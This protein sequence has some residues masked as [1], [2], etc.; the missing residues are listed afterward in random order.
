M[1]LHQVI[2]TVLKTLSKSMKKGVTLIE[3]LAVVAVVLVIFSILVFN[4]DIAGNKKKTRDTKRLADLA[5][6]DRAINEFQ[7]DSKSYPDS[8]SV[9][10]SSHILPP[11]NTALENSASGWI[12]QDFSA[13][14]SKMP[15]DPINDGD[16]HYAYFS[17]GSTYEIN[18]RL[19]YYLEKS[20][21][22][23]GNDSEVFEDGNNLLLISP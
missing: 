18:A 19:E 16:Y 11:G 9:L 17:N 1:A 14:M 6:L 4:I 8:G 12:A 2:A 13:Y 7:L 21:D 15:T 23:G 10:R 20:Q 5:V 3:L 22:D